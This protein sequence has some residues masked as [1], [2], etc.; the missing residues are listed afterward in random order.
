M[1]DYDRDALELLKS[2]T[3]G[4]ELTGPEI[5]S[6]EWL[7]GWEASTVTNIASVI[8]KSREAERSRTPGLTKKELLT[9]WGYLQSLKD[10]YEGKAREAAARPDTLGA[11]LAGDWMKMAAGIT[12]LQEKINQ[13]AEQ[14]E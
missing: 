5:H 1:A 2:S 3:G 8:K 4:A 14:C 7:A 11:Q 6:L 10:I 13:E 12:P 9:V